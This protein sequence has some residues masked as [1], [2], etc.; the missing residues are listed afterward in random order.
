MTFPAIALDDA[1]RR[2]L[3]AGAAHLARCVRPTLGPRGGSV[4]IER[5]YAEPQASRDGVFIAQRL[6]C[7][8]PVANL[9]LKIVREAARKAFEEAGDGT[10]TTMVLTGVI[11]EHGWRALAAGVA[12]RALRAGLEASWREADKLLQDQARPLG[13]E[14]AELARRAAGDVEL[15]DLVFEACERVGEGGQVLVEADPGTGARLE[16]RPGMTVPTPLLSEDF[17]T[18]KARFRADLEEAFILVHEDPLVT[19]DPMI[20]LLE[21][22]LDAGRPLVIFAEDI[23]GEALTSLALNAR[24]GV[25]RVLPV[26]APG[27]GK[28]RRGFFEDIA[29]LTGAEFFAREKGMSLRTC[30]LDQLGRAARV[31][32]GGEKLV[33]AGGAGDRDKLARHIARLSAD[34]EVETSQFDREKLEE[35]KARLLGGVAILRVGGRTEAD[36]VERCARARNAVGSL[37]SARRDGLLPG[38]GAA[39]LRAALTL[40]AMVDHDMEAEVKAGKTCLCRALRAPVEILAANA[41]YEVSGIREVLAS[42]LEAGWDIGSGQVGRGVGVLDPAGVIRTAL[43][44]AVGSAAVLLEA[45]AVVAQAPHPEETELL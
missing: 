8:D 12:P 1:A 29:Q 36:G 13:T 16:V 24:N 5:R 31:E 20:P 30:G 44:S 7:A 11:L 17:L 6:E 22:V 40:E 4:L 33:L 23:K 39:F 28:R 3:A 41:G 2:R 10:T 21:K 35:R 15:G 9:G 26:R 25:M 42:D 34:I 45:G 32:A 18:D 43:R 38:G 37:V 19:L 27:F 14:G